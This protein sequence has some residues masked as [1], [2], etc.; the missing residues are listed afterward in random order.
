M[1]RKIHKTESL[2]KEFL[3]S[4]NVSNIPTHN[5]WKPISFF[6]K[7]DRME[8][9]LMNHFN[10]DYNHTYM[11]AGPISVFN[12]PEKIELELMNNMSIGNNQS[13]IPWELS[14]VFNK[15]EIVGNEI[16]KTIKIGYNYT[17]NQ[18]ETKVVANQL[19]KL[20]DPD[21]KSE[22]NSLFCS[23]SDKE[24]AIIT[25][26]TEESNRD[27]S[28]QLALF[29]ETD[30]TILIPKKTEYAVRKY[31]DGDLLEIIHP[32]K[33]VAIELCLLML[34]NLTDTYY[35]MKGLIYE[36][37]DN[38]WEYGSIHTE[39]D[40]WKSL[41]SKSLRRQLFYE[42]NTYINVREALC[43]GT[44]N[45]PIIEC[46]NEKKLGEKCF[47]YRLGDDYSCRGV[48][49]YQIKSEFV[50]ELFKRQLDNKIDE[51]LR[52][53]IT[54]NLLI[55]Q[56]R[57]TLPTK[58][59]IKKE[60]KRLI[61]L[62]Y[63]TKSRKLLTFLN[64]HSKEYYKDHEN[65]SFV[66]ESLEIFDYLTQ[67]KGL[68][69]PNIG[70]DGSGGRIVDSF[71][72]MPSWIRKLCL[73]DGKK[74]TEV[75]YCCLHPN[76][77]VSIY[78]GNKKFIT[79]KAVAEELKI[80]EMIKN[81]EL[82]ALLEEDNIIFPE[83]INEIAE[84]KEFLS[85][86]KNEHLSFFN[87]EWEQMIHSPLFDYYSER[88]QTMMSNIYYD[89]LESKF[90]HKITSRKLFKKEVEIMT[91]VIARLN[92]EGIYVGYIYDALFCTED[93]KETVMRVMNEVVLEHGVWTTAK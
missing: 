6:K 53:P 75:D 67:K 76:I 38:Y 47:L 21:N 78:G 86:I 82:A 39:L 56:D 84:E 17:N 7:S 61:K 65:R 46:D 27:A 24:N 28:A 16:S 90:E 42:E 10:I 25:S 1:E 30:Y 62:K 89:K 41:Y 71:T 14:S 23:N 69:K 15:T 87:K 91:D 13:Y 29:Y 93:E 85:M 51:C 49:T 31:L 45:G 43:Q 19:I 79:H 35:R 36:S 55:M 64:K 12:F 37:G 33:K 34:T 40:G 60:A 52:N 2:N 70:G 74:L 20:S 92:A 44:K 57:I 81:N 11:P 26:I 77:A 88:E 4:F 50:K 32:N 22:T 5:P 73:I 58:L 8:L 83:A 63:R 68:W 72:L 18:S 80:K 9:E 66:E 59:E 3:N 48:E 54:R